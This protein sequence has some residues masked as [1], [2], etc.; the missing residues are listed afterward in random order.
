MSISTRRWNILLLTSWFFVILIAANR[1]ES[2]SREFVIG[3][4]EIIFTSEK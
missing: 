3:V 1:L 2:A 4:E